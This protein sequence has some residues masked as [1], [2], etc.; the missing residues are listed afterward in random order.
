[1]HDILCET[2]KM[3][4]KNMDPCAKINFLMKKGKKKNKKNI[5]ATGKS[6]A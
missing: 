3:N 6:G 4:S 5:G 2:D 1:M